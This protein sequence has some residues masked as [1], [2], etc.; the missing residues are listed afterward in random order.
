MTGR[1]VALTGADRIHGADP[2]VSALTVADGRIASWGAQAGAETV[3]LTR[4]GAARTLVAP[5]FVDAHLHTVQAGQVALGLDLHDVA[6][7]TELL[8]RLAAHVRLRPDARIVV[9]QGWDERHW[10]DPVPPTRTELDRAGDG[11]PVYLAR[12]DVHSAVVSSSLL[13]ELPEVTDAPG[14]AEDGLLRREAHHLCRGALDRFFSDGERREAARITLQRCAEL[15]VG[16]VHDLGGPHLG[17]VSDWVRVRETA[18]EVGLAAVGYWGELA[19]RESI[20]LAETYGM[21]GLAGDLCVDGAI[22]SRTAALTEN[23]ADAASRGF[24]YLDDDAIRDH[25]VACTRIG[26]Q[27]GFHCIGD[28]GV[29]AAVEGLRRAA[30]VVGVQALRAAGHRLEHVEMIDAADFATL[31]A[32]DVVASV[33]PAFDAAWG[34]A[35]ELY[36]TRLGATRSQTMNPFRGLA[37]AGVTLAFGT[38]APVTPTA[39]WQLVWQA[40]RH[41][42]PEERLSLTAAFAA[43]TTGGHRAA[44]D[45]DTGVIAPGRRALLAVWDVTDFDTD[46]SGL[47]VPEPDREPACLALL[48]GNRVVFPGPANRPG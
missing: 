8:D 1:A 23:Y 25:V 27:S 14:F 3:D 40:V 15:G 7:R 16:T 17:P 42:R 21:A 35:G 24:R 26:L 12:V 32:L 5:A 29:R 30:E 6:G 4:F 39:G 19:G 2:G 44:G 28:D 18:A 37:R 11:R 22:G 48:V 46:P 9:G 38:D 13:A 43:A 41:S 47:P 10:P 34:T 31:A 36:E 20:E 33:Q 45:R